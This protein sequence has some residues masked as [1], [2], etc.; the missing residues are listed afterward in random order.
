MFAEIVLSPGTDRVTIRDIPAL[1][2]KAIYPTLPDDTPRKVIELKKYPLTEDRAVNWCGHGVAP[3]EVSLS[4]SDRV[5]LASGV[6]AH[7][8]PL[9]LPIPEGEWELYRIAFERTPP[10]DW[11]LL[12]TF[13]NPVTQQH[14]L[15]HTVANEYLDIV[16][17]AATN[18][19]LRPRSSTT[20]LPLPAATGELFLDCFIPLDEFRVFA[21]QFEVGVKFAPEFTQSPRPLAVDPTLLALKPT[22]RV[23]VHSAIGSFSGKSWGPAKD[24]IEVLEQ[25]IA[26]QKDGFFTVGEAAQVLADSRSDIDVKDMIR[27]IGT[28]TVNGHRLAR[29]PNRLPLLAEKNFREDLDLV[30]V[31]DIDLWL[32]DL[33]TG[34]CFPQDK[35]GAPSLTSTVIKTAS[36]GAEHAKAGPSPLTTGDIAFCFAGLRDNTE[37]EWKDLIGKGRDWLERCLVQ[38]GT[39]G[40]GGAPKLWNPVCI[41][42]ALVRD[43]HEKPNS[44]R[45]KFQTVHLLQPWLEAWK[46]YEADNFDTE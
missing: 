19:Q 9:S 15:Q 16:R 46:T 24:Y 43:G 5:T 17:K 44:V 2:A 41:G 31:S 30:K 8:A 40:R 14:V 36:G 21:S 27:R 32:T 7:L 26:R 37:K 18:G 23:I 12:V 45:A 22:D 34:Y 11:R 1:F 42:A 35:R 25:T 38:P 6:W 33:G 10:T 28:A 29:N 3:F 13:E 4:K 20:V 39:R